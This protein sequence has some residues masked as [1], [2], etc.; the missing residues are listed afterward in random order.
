MIV[1]IVLFN[2][3][4][5]GSTSVAEVMERLRRL[6]ALPMVRSFA[7]GECVELEEVSPALRSREYRYGAV[8]TFEAEEE[9]RAYLHH[10]VH[11][12]VAAE[13]RA[14]FSEAKVIDLKVAEGT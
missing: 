13:L 11:R 12:E 9:V 5:E 6:G 10:P 2:L 14:H 8:F 4:G 7:A 1:H 3:R